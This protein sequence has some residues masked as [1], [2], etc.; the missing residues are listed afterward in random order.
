MD[1]KSRIYIAIDLKSFYASVECMEREIDPLTTNLVVADASRTDKTICLAVSPSLKAYGISGRARLFEVVQRVKEVNALRLNKAPGRVFTGA[2]FNDTELKSFPSLSLDYIAAPPRMAYY[3]EYSTRIYNIYLKY[4]APEDIHVYSID[5]VF[6]DVTNYLNTYNLSAR[7][8]TT[9]ILLEILNTTGITATAG[10]GTNLYLAKIAMDIQAKRIPIDENGVQIA[11]LDEMSYRRL[12]WAHRPLTDF[13]RV[14]KGYAKKLEKQGLFTMGDIARCSIG[15]PTDYYNEDLLYKIFG[16]NAELLIDHAWGWEP[17]TIA[18]IKE[19]KPS[20]KS[21]G[22]GQVLQCGYTYEKAKLIVWEM[23]DL[24]VLD[25]VDKRLVTD[26][27]VLTVG[28][29]IENLTDPDIRKLYKGEITTDGYGRKVPKSAHGT[30]NL[31]RYTSSTKLIIDA[32]MDLFER[33]V[34]KNL[35]VRRVNMSANRVV[36]EGV[37]ERSDGIEQLN[38]FTDCKTA[39]REKKEEEAELLRERKVQE[40]IL[41]LKKKFGKNVV[42]KGLN[43]EEGATTVDRNKQIGGHKA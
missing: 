33:I 22:S 8:L 37:V 18:D 19:Y 7:E 15:K 39:E 40:T 42:L 12:L 41:E 25:L 16:I 28:Y 27:I 6:M 21:I 5:E 20:A 38:L 14:G 9:K 23:A 3:I 29:D 43:L 1:I 13:W 17:C 30:V 32:V 26:Q 10:I 35:L 4:I 31:D 36:E 34:D 11:E 2:S 24:L